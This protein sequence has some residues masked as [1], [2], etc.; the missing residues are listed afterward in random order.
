MR[1]HAALR[2][3]LQPRDDAV[4][5]PQQVADDCR[6]VAGRIDADAGVARS[7]QNAVEDRG[8]NAPGIVEGM[9]GLQPHAHPALQAD[10]VAKGRGHGAFL[11]D[12]DQVL[13]AHQLGDACG[14]FRRD[15]ARELRQ[16]LPG[17]GVGQQPV[18]EAADGQRRDGCKARRIVAVDNQ[19]GDLVVLVRDNSFIEELLER[20]VG[21]RH[22]RRDHLLGAVG[23][24]AGE[25]VAGAR[26][27][28][29]G[30]QV[31]QIIEGVRGGIDGLA[32]DH[33][34]SGPI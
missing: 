27:G 24:N 12:Q 14:H 30:E 29:L 1:E 19:A 16:R 32:I 23:R 18:A 5:Q 11:G 20:D 17:R 31:A 15:P 9:I 8:G 4:E 26:R 28:R 10:G 25:T 7:E 13:I 6:V 22:A 33:D 3:Y 34:G 21:E 2:R